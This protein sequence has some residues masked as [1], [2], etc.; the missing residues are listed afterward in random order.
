MAVDEALLNNFKE[1]DLPIF[2]L[3]RWEPS[4][5]IG[6]FSNPALSIDLQRLH[7]Q[8][9]SYVR[10]ITGGGVLVHGGDIS[11]ALILPKRGFKDRGVKENYR[12]LCGFLI[13]FYKKLGLNANFSY[14]LNMQSSKSN[15][16]LA[17]NEAY[18]IIIKGSKIGGNAQRY[19]RLALLQHGSIPIRLD[20]MLFEDVFL[21]ES[22]LQYAASLDKMGI[23]IEDK[24]LTRLLRESFTQNLDVQL[25]SDTLR[26]LEQKSIEELLRHKYSQKRWNEYAQ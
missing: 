24:E 1:G 6:R 25:I 8:N 20:S 10:R 21:E 22:G 26:P 5:S 4:L 9:L 18:D 3:Y 19:T 15:I 7:I 17:A 14:D 2:R 16:C 23:D 11:Y 13:G 12:D